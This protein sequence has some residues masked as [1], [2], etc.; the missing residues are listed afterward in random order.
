MTQ[1][2]FRSFIQTSAFFIVASPRCHTM[3][4]SISFL[5]P[6]VF[7]AAAFQFRIWSNYR[8]SLQTASFHLFLGF[9]TDF[10]PPKHTLPSVE[11]SVF[12]T[13]PAHCKLFRRKNVGKPHAHTICRS[14]HYCILP[15]LAWLRTVVGIFL[16][17]SLIILTAYWERFHIS[18]LNRTLVWTRCG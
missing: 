10:H 18:L 7:P 9:P 3:A 12:N 6:S 2:I 5:Q 4:S 11:S 17:R 8:A 15:W 1:D 14:I 16:S 13:W